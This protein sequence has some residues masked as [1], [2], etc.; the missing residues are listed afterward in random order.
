MN[1]LTF[2]ESDPEERSRRVISRKYATIKKQDPPYSLFA[3]QICYSGCWQI[4]LIFCILSLTLRRLWNLLF[5]SLF[6]SDLFLGK[7]KATS[8]HHAPLPQQKSKTFITCSALSGWVLTNGKLKVK[9]KKDLWENSRFS[10]LPKF[11][12]T[13]SF[14]SPWVQ[15]LGRENC[16]TIIK[17]GWKEHGTLHMKSQHFSKLRH[18]LLLLVYYWPKSDDTLQRQETIILPCT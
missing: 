11:N 4:Q 2:Q 14:I 16:S 15:K 7:K 13:P 3:F 18:A 17:A 10:E 12:N 8:K 6:F 5:S 1:I 9:K